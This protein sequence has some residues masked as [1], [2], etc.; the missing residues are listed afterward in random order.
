M[1]KMRIVLSLCVLA[2][3]AS[4]GVAE[5]ASQDDYQA[6]LQR[7]EA[8]EAKI[9]QLQEQ[10][11]HTPASPISHTT[12]VF[13]ENAGSVSLDSLSASWEE[14]WKAQEEKNEELSSAIKKSVQHS[15]SGTKKIKIAGRTHIDYWGIPD[16]SPGINEIETGSPTGSPQDRTGFRRMRIHAEGDINPNISFKT[17]LELA[18]GNDIE[19]REIG[20]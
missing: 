1:I 6:L 5:A 15:G 19:L 12:P 14:R 4:G 3:M 8:A 13:D 18:S 10:N 20:L 2:A 16:S 9:Q 7:L 17:E 11:T